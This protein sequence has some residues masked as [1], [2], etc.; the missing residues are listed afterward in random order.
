MAPVQHKPRV[1]SWASSLPRYSVLKNPIDIQTRTCMFGHEILEEI[2][3]VS[4]VVDQYSFQALSHDEQ[5]ETVLLLV[6]LLH[7]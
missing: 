6:S 5:D 4:L 7:I 2:V 3:A 1:L